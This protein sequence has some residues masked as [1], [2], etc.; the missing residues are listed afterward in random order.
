MSSLQRV[1]D[2][3]H[4][5]HETQMVGVRVGRQMIGLPISAVRDV[6]S[7]E[8]MTPV[9]RSGDVV[10]GLVNLRGHIVTILDLAH[11]LTG[12]GRS[13]DKTKTP[14]AVG[15]EW[16]N[17]VFGL[18][19]D[20]IGDVIALPASAS[21]PLP[22]NIADGWSRVSKRVH[23]LDNE[24]MIELDLATLLDSFALQAA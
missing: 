17:E 15:V 8:T 5:G 22:P 4:S 19:V 24:L 18:L 23:K 1:E 11:L 3:Q 12:Q 20:E 14:M 16:H 9:P 10:A 2:A 21:E 13:R 6:F 7:I